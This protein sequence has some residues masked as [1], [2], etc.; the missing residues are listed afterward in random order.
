MAP[1]EPAP[2]GLIARVR[3]AYWDFSGA[4]RRIL[5]ER[6]GDAIVLSFI[7]IAGFMRFAG[8]TVGAVLV[9]GRADFSLMQARLLDN[10]LLL[11]GG[12]YVLSLVLDILLRG[13]GGRGDWTATR[14]A[15][16]WSL[17]VA[18][19]LLFALGVI[20]GVARRGALAPEGSFVTP[21]LGAAALALLGLAAYILS[22]GLA[23]AHGFKSPARVLAGVVIGT[24]V[25]SLLWVGGLHLAAYLASV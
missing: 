7:L 11:P 19:P 15:V 1:S 4:A 22:A 10:L 6:P 9:E 12:A 25:V 21:L 8:L 20:D 16:G 24:I 17:V 23:A 18:A 2:A 14:L 13:A 5:A 3:A